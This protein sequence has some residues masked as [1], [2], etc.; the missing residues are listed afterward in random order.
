LSQG[1]YNRDIFAILFSIRFQL[2]TIH[3]GIKQLLNVTG[4]NEFVVRTFR[5]QL[6]YAFFLTQAACSSL[7]VHR[8]IAPHSMMIK[9]FFL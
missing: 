9:K 8:E 7:E 2:P 5:S 3:C 6:F 4:G 1:P